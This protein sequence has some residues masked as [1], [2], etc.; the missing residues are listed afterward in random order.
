MDR[1]PLALVARV[2]VIE[3]LASYGQVYAFSSSS[4]RPQ[5]PRKRVRDGIGPRKTED[6]SRH[7][8]KACTAQ[9]AT[10]IFHFCNDDFGRPFRAALRDFCRSRGV[11]LTTVFSG[12]NRR[13]SVKL[14]MRV[15]F[16]AQA[17]R[18]VALGQ[19]SNAHRSLIVDDVNAAAFV[20]SIPAGSV[21]VITG[22]NQI[23]RSAAIAR[24]RNFVNLH[25]SVL[26]SYAGRSPIEW[27]IGNGETK[28]GFTLHEVTTAIDGGPIL[29]QS[30]V[31]I[32]SLDILGVA[33]LIG[34]Q[35]SPVLV[36]YLTALLDGRPWTA[37]RADPAVVYR[38]DHVRT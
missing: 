9:A 38:A 5:P 16:A 36:D 31:E 6:D 3:L 7:G 37:V 23:F 14:Q 27:A 2:H 33:A 35:A 4:V 21:G 29:Y 17:V 20:A 1:P 28:T 11:A 19:A 34:R 25:P 30:V 24:F 26:P 10:M 8:R 12:K 15:A 22:F 32:G 18:A 13:A